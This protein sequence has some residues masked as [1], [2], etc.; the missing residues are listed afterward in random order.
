MYAENYSMGRECSICGSP[1]TDENPDGIGCTCREVWK[2]ARNSAFYHFCGLDLWIEKTRFWAN[3]FVDTCKNIKF[4]SAFR[5]GFHET[6]S[7]MVKE[8][9]V[10]ISKKML[11]VIT[12]YLTGDNAD[13]EPVS[14]YPKLTYEETTAVYDEERI[15]FSKMKEK[16]LNNTTQEQNEYIINL[17]K[18]FYGMSSVKTNN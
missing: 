11:S 15:I 18:K 1:I 8:D 3:L 14:G 4:R 6:I 17:A 16:W 2:K 12:S 5:K 9:N 10:R 7:K 13:G